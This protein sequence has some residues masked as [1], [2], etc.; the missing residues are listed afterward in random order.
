MIIIYISGLDGCGKTTQAKLLEKNL[1]ENGI[2]T[3]YL[4]LRWEPSIIKIINLIK[5]LKKNDLNKKL[6]IVENENVR[7][8]KWI[9]LKRKIL[10]FTFIK[11]L[12]LVYAFNDYWISCRKKLSDN[13]TKVIVVDRYVYD[14]IIDQAINIDISSKKAL[15]LMHNSF[16]KFVLPD[17]NVIIDI[18]AHVG[19]KRKMD[20]T[21]LKYL[22]QREHYYKTLFCTNNSVHFDGLES[23]DI[24]FS[25]IFEVVKS[26]ILERHFEET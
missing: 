19:Y 23:I 18:P 7:H 17:L 15:G 11:K 16:F 1:N 3:K 26:Y 13:Q 9:D 12:W 14:L 25:K 22:E 21:P 10:S 2:E 4:W 20:G 6:N 5:S 8:T 24:L